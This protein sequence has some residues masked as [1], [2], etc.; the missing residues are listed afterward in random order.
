MC[1]GYESYFKNIL[2]SMYSDRFK[3]LVLYSLAM[4]VWEWVNCSIFPFP[5]ICSNNDVHPQKNSEMKLNTS[6]NL[7]CLVHSLTLLLPNRSGLACMKEIFEP[8]SRAGEVNLDNSKKNILSFFKILAS[9]TGLFV[10]ELCHHPPTSSP[11]DRLR[12]SDDLG[13][14][15]E[16]RS[17]RREFGK[18]QARNKLS[19]TQGCK[20]FLKH[21]IN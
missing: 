21:K 8:V 11:T 20:N 16:G 1:F 7:C 14:R 5:A 2:K 10:F 18:T 19:R 13:W 6:A 9:A 15:K 17:S 12:S 4:R 3:R